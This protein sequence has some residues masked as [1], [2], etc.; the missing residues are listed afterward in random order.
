MTRRTYRN[1]PVHEVVID[2]QFLSDAPPAEVSRIP[3]LLAESFGVATKSVEKS[4]QL[5]VGPAGSDMVTSSEE[6]FAG[7]RF[8]E[9]G[10]NIWV[11]SCGPRRIGLN[12]ARSVPW[13]QGPYAGWESIRG[14][15][16]R[17]LD[18][19]QSVY[20]APIRKVAVRYINRILV[21]HDTQIE[22]WF[23]IGMK[24]PPQAVAVHTFDLNQTWVCAPGGQDG[25]SLHLR[26]AR[27][28]PPPQDQESVALM[29]D[30]EVF[31]LLVSR[32]PDLRNV[33]QW[34]DRAHEIENDTFES[35]ITES[36]RTRFDESP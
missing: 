32:A 23:S 36:L 34:I 6:R 35:S 22:Q 20:Q 21:P 9:K 25:H 5:G 3:A 29:L 24:G 17:A 11:L 30:I 33:K 12:C 13:P 7:W 26:F 18:L 10:E 15:F 31:N 27:I 2:I 8:E 14:R 28:D 19:T 4:F 16:S 1:P